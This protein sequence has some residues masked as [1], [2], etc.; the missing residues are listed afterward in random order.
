MFIGTDLGRDRAVRCEPALPD[1]PFDTM[2]FR[3]RS[4]LPPSPSRSNMLP[5][6][7][8]H[9]KGDALTTEAPP[10]S[11]SPQSV[12][13]SSER[14]RASERRSG[15]EPAGSQEWHVELISGC[16]VAYYEVSIFAPPPSSAAAQ[17]ADSIECIAV[18]LATRSF[19]LS[20]RQPGWDAHSYG[21]HSDDG[22]TFHGSGSRSSTFGPRFGPGDVIG[23]GI[24]LTTREVFFT[25]NGEYLGVAFNAKAMRQPLHPVV[26]LDS[27]AAIRFN[28]GQT[29]F[30][31][32][33]SELPMSL[34]ANHPKE[35]APAP[36][37]LAAGALRHLIGVFSR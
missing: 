30:Q 17:G 37:S 12:A 24:S 31:F 23:C 13:V 22:R 8:A 20:G 2:Q 1:S 18:G 15:S 7:A 32:D 5:N 19:P 34:L 4:R 35:L 11:G 36:V 3:C 27:R 10:A 16:S 29:P 21:Y 9:P 14:L 28:F 25:C 6:S 26:G 33:L